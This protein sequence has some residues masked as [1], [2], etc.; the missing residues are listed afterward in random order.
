[1][2]LLALEICSRSLQTLRLL[3]CGGSTPPPIVS[4]ATRRSGSSC[5]AALTLKVTAGHWLGPPSSLFCILMIGSGSVIRSVLLSGMVRGHAST[6]RFA[7]SALNLE[8]GFN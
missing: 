1:M 8:N 7:C 6:G 3:A 2:T 4:T 5:L